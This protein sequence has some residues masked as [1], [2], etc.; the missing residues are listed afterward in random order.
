MAA[1][2]TTA[3]RFKKNRWGISFKLTALILLVSAL[4]FAVV[5]TF[6]IQSI[7]SSMRQQADQDFAQSSVMLATQSSGA[8]RW[9]NEAH[10]QRIFTGLQNGEESTLLAMVAFGKKDGVTN[11]TTEAKREG[12]NNEVLQSLLSSSQ[13]K[14]PGKPVV[15]DHGDVVLVSTPVTSGSKNKVVGGIVTA[16]DSSGIAASV[17][18]QTTAFLTQ[19][20]A[21][22]GLVSLL[23]W[24]AVSRL[25][26]LPIKSAVAAAQKISQKEL[27]EPLP[28][29]GGDEI[30]ELT[31]TLNQIRENLIAGDESE[32]VALEFGR[33]KKALDCAKAA[34]VLADDHHRIV[35]ANDAAQR[36]FADNEH[37][38]K[39]GGVAINAQQLEGTDLSVFRKYSGLEPEQVGNLAENTVLSFV[40]GDRSFTTYLTPVRNEDSQRIGT[41]LEWVDRTREVNAERE[42]QAMVDAAARG[43][44]EQRIDSRGMQSFY[45]HIAQMLNQLA[46]ISQTGLNDTLDM[47]TK[48]ADGNLSSRMDKHYEGIFAEVKNRCNSTAERLEGVVMEIR[49]SASELNSGARDISGGN[50]D[51]SR[52]TEEQ[53]TRLM[54]TS[55]A[56]DDI[57]QTLRRNSE[58]AEDANRLA[59]KARDEAANGGKI[60]QQ[61]IDAVGKISASSQQISDITSVID[62]LAFQTNL[63][64]LNAAVEAARAGEQ[65]R[66][67]AVVA[68][69]VRN[70]AGRSAE[71][72]KEIKGLIEDSVNK[73]REGEK[74][75]TESGQTLDTILE[76]I[77]QVS[78]IISEIAEAS[79]SQSYGVDQ[80]NDSVSALDQVTQQNTALVEEAAAASKAVG[81]Q[82]SK[83]DEMV[84]FFRTQSDTQAGGFGSGGSGAPW[85][86]STPAR[87]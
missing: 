46:E 86:R 13:Q 53:A 6:A 30:G 84:K 75:V 44:F 62:E 59:S 31:Y 11:F 50:E 36:F 87:V 69:E 49:T 67:F 55:A 37:A 81:H 58:S 45:Q 66:G 23:M 29:K 12:F 47:L 22:V 39:S 54:Q 76:S 63:L 35:Y 60:A 68:S 72:A 74:L 71:A 83:L 2:R 15:E 42:V 4:G 10:I 21:T 14:I 32:K 65:G 48:L 18:E 57:A 80:I 9:K 1:N 17:R 77:R 61:A 3:S 33:I 24:V 19:A 5:G 7:N 51:L 38:M 43:D 16:W 40:E 56:M 82:A 79:A 28:V 70:L 20:L 41:V 8:V 34:V 27:G 52:R 26:A 85:A 78:T 73:V 25:I 64:A